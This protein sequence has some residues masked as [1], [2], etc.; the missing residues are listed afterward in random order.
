MSDIEILGVRCAPGAKASGWAEVGELASGSPVRLPI[1]IVN[2]AAE[3]KRLALIAALHG[4]E[5]NGIEAINR[6]LDELDPSTMSG[7]VVAVPIANPLAFMAKTRMTPTDY[8]RS[9]MNRVFPGVDGDLIVA[10]MASAIFENV[11]RG[12]DAFVDMHEGGYAFT[13]RFIIV[14]D[15]TDP[16]LAER[17]LRLA[18]AFPSDVPI[19]KHPLDATAERLGHGRYSTHQANRIGIPAITPEL[20]GGGHPLEEYLDVSLTGFRNIARDLGILAGSSDGFTGHTTC[21]E[22]VWPR[23]DHGGI[24][25]CAIEV[26]QRLSEGELIGVVRS[27]LGEVVEEIRAPFDSVILDIRN[28]AMIMTGEWTIHCGRPVEFATGE[29]A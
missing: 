6:F 8:E 26:G 25:E 21:T 19:M 17:N 7:S 4:D 1:R 20:G 12:S 2:G 27:T 23:P 3:G 16:E 11:I 10:H 14:P 5:V 15:A 29:A 24:W 13:A 28:T 9:N 22:G 18:R